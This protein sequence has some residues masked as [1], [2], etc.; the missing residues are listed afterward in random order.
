MANRIATTPEV[1]LKAV[2]DRLIAQVPDATEANTYVSTVSRE[3]PPNP[4]TT[5]FECSWAHNF[6]SWD[7][8]FTGAGNEGLHTVMTLMVTISTTL[9]L[10]EVGHD[11]QYL[12]HQQFG[13]CPL[14]TRV[15]GA[16]SNFDPTNEDD[17]LILAQPMRL[18]QGQIPPK[19]D[20]RRGY[21]TVML[22]CEFDWD[23]EPTV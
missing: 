6:A 8:E 21:V 22:E 1:I 18:T 19:D 16:L 20:R 7:P 4:G 10:D 13:V 5:M 23:L 9:Q 12:S 11:L 14:I 3:L 17:E 15:L 2:V